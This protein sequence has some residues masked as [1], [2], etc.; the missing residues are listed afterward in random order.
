VIP[1]Q[2]ELAMREAGISMREAGIPGPYKWI[3][4]QMKLEKEPLHTSWTR[5]LKLRRFALISSL[6]APS[7]VF[8]LGHWHEHERQTRTDA[9]NH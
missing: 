2:F 7:T 1:E 5:L 9:D 4:K 3:G 8:L 6:V